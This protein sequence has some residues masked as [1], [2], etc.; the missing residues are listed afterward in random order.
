[1][2]HG[3]VMVLA[4][5][6][7][8]GPDGLAMSSSSS[9]EHALQSPRVLVVDDE[10]LLANT[11]A[12]ILRGAGFTTRTAYDGWEALDAIQ[13]FQPQYILTDVVMPRMNGVQLA[14]TVS[15]MFPTIK[16]LLF[17]GQVGISEIL[18]E[19]HQSGY[20][21][22]LLAKPVHPLKLIECLKSFNEPI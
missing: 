22:P 15:K 6:P 21:F 2:A 8:W 17:S 7:A 9:A 13:S 16:V 12:A 20:E 14:I 4:G 18:E 11:T 10:R 19:S 5:K 3:T 1:M